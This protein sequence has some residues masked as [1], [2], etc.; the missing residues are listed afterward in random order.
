VRLGGMRSTCRF[1]L[2]I[3]AACVNIVCETY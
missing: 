3:Q 1:D 2:N